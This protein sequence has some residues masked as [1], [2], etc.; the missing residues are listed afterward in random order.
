MRQ[1]E[2][3]AEF[4][5]I[6]REISRTRRLGELVILFLRVTCV[7]THIHQLF[8]AIPRLDKANSVVN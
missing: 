8:R 4:G 2:T 5:T 1:V 3:P 7:L 6:D